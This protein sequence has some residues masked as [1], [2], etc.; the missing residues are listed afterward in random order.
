MLG[1]ATRG[2]AGMAASCLPSKTSAA[3]M[4]DARRI[5][6]DDD[7]LNPFDTFE[8]LTTSSQVARYCSSLQRM[9]NF[10]TQ[11]IVT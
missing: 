3:W 2:R 4:I 1:V 10:N 11:A 8:P 5:K 9:A 7:A 6:L